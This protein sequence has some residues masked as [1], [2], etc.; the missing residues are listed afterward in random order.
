MTKYTYEFKVKL[1]QGYWSGDVSYPD[2]M[3]KYNISS[4]T[5]IRK[6]VMQASARGLAQDLFFDQSFL[7]VRNSPQ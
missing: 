7:A 4:M 2:L 3:R 1:V 5:T 6:W